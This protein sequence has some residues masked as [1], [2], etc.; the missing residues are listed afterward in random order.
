MYPAH[1]MDV[2]FWDGRNQRAD[3]SGPLKRCVNKETLNVALFGERAF[4]DVIRLR[5]TK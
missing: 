3:C 5:I 2:D 4:A 1:E